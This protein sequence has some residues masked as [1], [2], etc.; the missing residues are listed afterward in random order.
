VVKSRSQKSTVVA[1]FDQLAKSYAH[2]YEG[3]SA[4][5]H[6]FR[7]DMHRVCELL[8]DAPGR[9]LDVGCGAGMMVDWLIHQ[10]YEVYGVDTSREMIRICL[11]RFGHTE[12][13]VFSVGAI[14]QLPC[15]TD[16]FDAVICKGVFDFLDSDHEALAELARVCKPGGTLILTLQHLLSPWRA[17]TYYVARRRQPDHIRRRCYRAGSFIRRLQT[18][19][20]SVQDVVYCN[21]QL[22]LK[23]FDR[24]FPE[25][26]VWTAKKLERYCRHSY[27]SWMATDFVIKAIKV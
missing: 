11:E 4:L 26:A 20:M 7:I 21:F 19:N 25:P 15:K 22:F 18:Y 27:L 10:G 8:G 16:G 5:A 12:S 1:H 9:V 23:P 17:W 13:A 2:R 24:L 6:A 14:E 3:E